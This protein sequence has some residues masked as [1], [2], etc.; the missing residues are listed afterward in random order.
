MNF[1]NFLKQKSIK[2]FDFGFDID[3]WWFYRLFF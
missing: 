2:K 3:D 1:A